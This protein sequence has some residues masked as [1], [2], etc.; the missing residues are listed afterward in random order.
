MGAGMSLAK[1]LRATG[2]QVLRRVGLGL[3]M[4]LAAQCE[5]RDYFEVSLDLVITS[6][7]IFSA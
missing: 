4:P 7:S 5:V 1:A 2:V 6:F 3:V